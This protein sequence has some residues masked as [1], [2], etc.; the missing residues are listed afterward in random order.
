MRSLRTVLPVVFL[1]FAAAAPAADFIQPDA[2]DY[3]QIV[4]P[5]PAPGSVAEEAD[6]LA[7][8]L[9]EANRTPEQAAL[10][11]H[12]ERYTVFNLLRPVLGEWATPE[13]LPKLAAFFQQAT[14]ETRP[15]NT[16]AKDAFARP[17]PHL[18]LPGFK[19]ACAEKPD[20]FSYPSGHA[21]GSALHAALLG[22]LLPKHAAEW[23][24]LAGEVRLSR[25]YGGAHFPSD[26]IAGQRLGEAVA[27]EML[28]SPA[29]Q[30]ALEEIRAEL[31]PFLRKK[32]A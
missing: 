5:P 8:R 16:A 13:N 32:A 25:L 28:K 24:R 19:T 4:P 10:A 15:F 30:K 12:H 11:L 27:R 21:T 9:L 6:H 29:T 17:R 3:R 7:A 26:V 22:A 20:G 2:L 31:A 14:V 18:T 1:V 23:E